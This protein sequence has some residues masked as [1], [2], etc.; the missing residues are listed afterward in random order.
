[1]LFPDLTLPELL[2]QSITQNPEKTALVFGDKRVSYKDLG[3]RV[4][5]LALRLQQLG[6]QRGDHVGLILPNWPE[7]IE[8]YFAA[9]KVGAVVV[10]FSTQLRN[11]ELLYVLNHS[12]TLIL[13]IPNN[14]NQFDYP[15]RTEDLRP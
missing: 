11:H 10:P 3:S 7:F 8:I 15:N 1:M 13:F 5:I 9:F 4:D 12:E 6:V 2:N 14:F